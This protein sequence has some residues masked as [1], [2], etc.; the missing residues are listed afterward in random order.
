MADFTK[1]T[2]ADMAAGNP[3]IN[4]GTTGSMREMDRASDDLW[5]QDDAHWR[6]HHVTRPY[7]HAD[8]GYE[9]YQPAYRYGHSAARQHTGREWDD[10]SGDL[11][12]GW[13][14]ARGE[15]RQTWHEAKDAVRDAW[16]RVRGRR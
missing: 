2:V 8:R 15:S 13:D 7:V 5:N 16:D 11:E 10:V 4:L 14:H 1:N 12:R 6:E 9:H 3:G